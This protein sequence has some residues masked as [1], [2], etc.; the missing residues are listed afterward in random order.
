VLAAPGFLLGLGCR[1]IRGFGQFGGQL[2]VS[3]GCGSAVGAC[4]LGSS[5]GSSVS[6]IVWSDC[7]SS[8]PVHVRRPGILD[9]LT[10]GRGLHVVAQVSA[11]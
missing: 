1:R 6:C 2:Q 4:V 9:R 5:V 8:S 3:V 11:G 7:G 10:L